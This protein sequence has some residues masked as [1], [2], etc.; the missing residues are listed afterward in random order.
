MTSFI[1][2]TQII[3]TDSPS[4]ALPRLVVVQPSLVICVIGRSDV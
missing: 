4:V 1:P 2:N 3:N